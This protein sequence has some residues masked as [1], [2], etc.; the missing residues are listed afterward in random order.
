MI[1]E[2]IVLRE[3]VTLTTYIHDQSGQGEFQIK[4]TS[5]SHKPGRYYT[6]GIFRRS[7]PGG[8]VS[9]PVEYTRPGGAPGSAPGGYQA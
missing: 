1:H 2:T 3:K 6:D 4:K 9:D 8:H 7:L 5:G